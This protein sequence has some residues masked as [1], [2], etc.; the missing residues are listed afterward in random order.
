MIA[1]DALEQKPLDQLL[2]QRLGFIIPFI[3]GG[4][5]AEDD[6][7][8]DAEVAVR[9]QCGAGKFQSMKT[10]ADGRGADGHALHLRAKRAHAGDGGG[11]AFQRVLAVEAVHQVRA[12]IELA[13]EVEFL[14]LLGALV[15]REQCASGR[16]RGRDGRAAAAR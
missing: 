9:L 11:E 10:K 7:L 16:P 3:L 4:R 15:E 13:G 6:V 12:Q 8:A 14:A 2:Q 5:C 1:A